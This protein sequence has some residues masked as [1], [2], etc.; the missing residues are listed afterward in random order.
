MEK[1]SIDKQLQKYLPFILI[2]VTILVGGYLLVQKGIL[3]LP[4]FGKKSNVVNIGKPSIVDILFTGKEFNFSYASASASLLVDIAKFDKNEQWQGE[5]SIEESRTLGR[6]IL[7]LVDRDRKKTSSYILKNLNLSGVDVIKFNINLRSDPDNLETI[8]LIFGNKGLTSF[9]RFPLT[10]LEEGINYFAIPKHRFFLVE[11]QV[12]MKSESKSQKDATA[13]AAK[14]PFS[15]DKIE[16]VQL[17]LIS[18]PTSKANIDVGWIRA[19]K[20]DVFTPDWNWTGGEHFFSLDQDRNG[21]IALLVQSIGGSVATFRKLSS[22]KDFTYSAK[23]TSLRKGPI[24]LFFRGDYKNGHGYYLA[25]GGLGTSDWF[26][27]KYGLVDNQPKT[28]VFLDGQIGNFEFSG[29]QPFWL[30]V[31]A[32]GNNITGFFSLDGEGFTKLGE[33]NDNEFG[34]GGVGVVVSNEGVGYFDDFNFIQK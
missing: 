5:G 4:S 32:R 15:W 26:I 11:E 22:A 20:E 29:D 33:V 23:I 18:R 8:N 19:E 10:N 16:R 12:E 13:A 31:I 25:V 3:S 2:A 14:I 24:G 27:S 34:A 21:K 17:E 28:T 30:K 6:D 7:S 1:E 9:Y